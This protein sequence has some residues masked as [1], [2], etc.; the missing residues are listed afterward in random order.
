VIGSKIAALVRK[1]KAMLT[2]L[3]IAV[4]GLFCALGFLHFVTNA[5]L[6]AAKRWP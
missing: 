2:L 6:D 4:V 5:E 3:T 1:G